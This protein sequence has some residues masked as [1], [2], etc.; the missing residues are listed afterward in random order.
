MRSA[1]VVISP[2]LQRRAVAHVGRRVGLVLGVAQLVEVGERPRDVLLARARLVR[3]RVDV[4]GRMRQIDVRRLDAVAGGLLQAGDDLLPDGLAAWVHVMQ[5]NRGG[6]RRPGLPEMRDGPRQQPQHA[7]DALE[8]VERRGLRRQ[9]LQDLG[10]AADSWPG[11]L[12]PSPAGAASS[13]T[14][15]RFADHTA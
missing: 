8:R 1:A 10:G 4:D 12:P 14:A 7:A 9:R 3:R 6:V 11:R 13:A 5:V 15:S 2:L